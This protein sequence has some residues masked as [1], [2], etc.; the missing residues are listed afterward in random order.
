MVSSSNIQGVGGVVLNVS[1]NAIYDGT[2]ATISATAPSPFDVRLSCRLVQ[3]LKGSFDPATSR[4]A[5]VLIN[6]VHVVEF[7]ATDIVFERPIEPSHP[8]RYMGRCVFSRSFRRSS[9][10]RRRQTDCRSQRSC[11]ISPTCIELSGTELA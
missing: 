5:C 8:T 7:I 9:S 3:L 4:L 2:A 10:S 11:W 6:G 1:L